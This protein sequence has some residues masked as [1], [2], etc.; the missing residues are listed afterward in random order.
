MLLIQFTVEGDRGVGIVDEAA[1]VQMLAGRLADS[2]WK[3][4]RICRGSETVWKKPFLTCER[5]MSHAIANLVRIADGDRIEVE[6]ECVG[7]ALR[8]VVRFRIGPAPA[9]RAL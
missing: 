5:N 2:V 9:I 6:A 4:A 1:P 3:A 8:N 7:P